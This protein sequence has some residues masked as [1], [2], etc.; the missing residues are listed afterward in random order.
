MGDHEGSD[1]LVLIQ[2]NAIPVVGDE[3]SIEQLIESVEVSG[4]E[5]IRE[6]TEQADSDAAV[7]IKEA[8][9]KDDIIKKRHLEAVKKAVEMER[10]K[11]LAKIKEERRMQLTGVKDEVFRKAFLEAWKIL[12]SARGHADYESNFKKMLQEAVLE[13]EGEEIQLHIDKK[14]EALCKKLLSEL[15]LNCEIVTDI[16]C[17]GG[18][19]AGTKDGRF[20]VSNTIE[21]RF[22]TAK[23][24]L[25]PEIITILYGGQGGV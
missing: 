16:S 8:Q 5:K 13:L 9:A 3:M 4:Q 24:L 12:S 15:N 22:E 1:I 6:L 18:L 2:K 10:N 11:S 20:I 19:N 14:D 23:V 17:A 25:K 21:S 7:T